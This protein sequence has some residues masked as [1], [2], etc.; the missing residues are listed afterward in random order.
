MRP[1]PPPTGPPSVR[2]CRHGGRRGPSLLAWRDRGHQGQYA[3]PCHR[4]RILPFWRHHWSCQ[5]LRVV[6]G[7]GG[8]EAQ[9][10]NQGSGQ[11]ASYLTQA[12]RPCGAGPHLEFPH[13][14]CPSQGLPL[15]PA[16]S[17]RLIASCWEGH[18]K[19]RL[20]ET[21][22]ACSTSLPRSETQAKR[23][24]RALHTHHTLRPTFVSHRLAS[25]T[26]MGEHLRT[27]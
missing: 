9:L 13:L 12:V 16:S 5:R 7:L 15:Q 27:R 20:T 18:S 14:R 21:Q 19:D 26:G 4:G 8:Q 17:P 10:L 6:K 11:S 24:F 23:Q 25:S 1:P 22:T 2:D 3:S